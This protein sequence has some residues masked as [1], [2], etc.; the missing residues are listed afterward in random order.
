MEE[1]R[2]ASYDGA[3]DCPRCFSDAPDAA[4]AY[5]GVVGPAGHTTL[6]IEEV[7]SA[8]VTIA[9]CPSCRGAFVEYEALVAIENA[10]RREKKRGRPASWQA[11]PTR[12]AWDAPTP[13]IDC[14][15]CS[16][17]TIRREWGIGTL[18]YVDV[19]LECR[20]V[21]LDGGELEAIAD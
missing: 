5:R 10:A 9:R 3:V 13:A 16:S 15:S 12:R 2:R 7:S 14:P 11:A 1:A 17:A 4:T 20:G 21:W 6:Q 19:C 18:L 8:G